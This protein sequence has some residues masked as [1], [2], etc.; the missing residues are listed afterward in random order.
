MEQF[1]EQIK[2]ID[3]QIQEVSLQKPKEAV[4]KSAPKVT[5]SPKTRQEVQN[6]ILSNITKA[7]T[8]LDRIETVSSEKNKLDGNVD[9]LK[10]E[11]ELDKSHDSTGSGLESIVEKEA[12]A[13]QMQSRSQGLMQ[14]IYD[15]LDEAAEIL[16]ENNELSAEKP[17]EGDRES[18]SVSHKNDDKGTDRISSKPANSNAAC[19]VKPAPKPR[20]DAQAEEQADASAPQS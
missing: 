10:S 1:D 5:S 12:L 7:S 8:T 3:Q 17:V 18:N 19:T 13:A 16:E 2:E 15:G 6:D 9:V 20:E 14:D 11:I 4:E